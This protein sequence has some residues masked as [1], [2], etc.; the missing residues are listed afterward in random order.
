MLYVLIDSERHLRSQFGG[1][2]QR[3]QRRWLSFWAQAFYLFHAEQYEAFD[4][5]YSEAVDD[6]LE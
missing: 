5:A 4:A 3:A 1:T 2:A 6:P